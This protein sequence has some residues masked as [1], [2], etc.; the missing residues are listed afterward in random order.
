MQERDVL[1]TLKASRSQE[2][3]VI[4]NKNDHR[5]V[6]H[7]RAL[8]ALLY[9]T[10][11]RKELFA[12]RNNRR[13]REL[14][15]VLAFN[16]RGIVLSDDD[17]GRD[18]LHIVA[19]HLLKAKRKDPLAAFLAWSQ[20]RAPWSDKSEL[21]SIMRCAAADR[22]RWTADELAEALGLTFSVRM[23]LGVTTIGSIDKNKVQR[24]ERRATNSRKRSEARRRKQGAKSQA[25]SASRNKPW[26]AMG[27]GRSRYY[28]L[29]KEGRLDCFERCNKR[30][31][32]GVFE[33]VHTE[34]AS[35]RFIIT[36]GQIWKTNSDA[37]DQSN[38]ESAL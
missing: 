24:K 2:R 28:A 1:N 26:I 9:K 12:A 17:A 8:I 38:F 33:T 21:A 11:H 31:N 25:Q 18:D 30:G 6:A 22:R 16:H 13:F 36:A 5:A 10:S 19:C 3:L 27:I 32:T 34:D 23:A 37:C 20:Q 4:V 14:E 35:T 7:A 15:T 29:K